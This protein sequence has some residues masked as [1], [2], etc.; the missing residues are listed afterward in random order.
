MYH[1]V[2]SKRKNTLLAWNKQYGHGLLHHHA[3]VD[4]DKH[5]FVSGL[6]FD[7]SQLLINSGFRNTVISLYPNSNRTPNYLKKNHLFLGISGHLYLVSMYYVQMCEIKVQLCPGF[8]HVKFSFIQRWPRHD[9][10]HVKLSP[11]PETTQWVELPRMLVVSRTQHSFCNEWR[12]SR[13]MEDSKLPIHFIYFTICA[14]LKENYN[15]K[16]EFIT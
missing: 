4:I 12:G 5:I 1:S 9:F 7:H 16:Q 13:R 14:C 15:I 11:L 10:A 2:F 3:F 8:Q 6:N